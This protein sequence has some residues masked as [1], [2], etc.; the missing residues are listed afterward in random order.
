MEPQGFSLVAML[1]MVALA[2]YVGKCWGE[3]G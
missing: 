2:F 1:C 3:T